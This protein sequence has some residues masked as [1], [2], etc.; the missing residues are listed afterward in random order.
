MTLVDQH[1]ARSSII[2]KVDDLPYRGT[3]AAD[4]RLTLAVPS[5]SDTPVLQWALAD[6]APCRQ[7]AT[8][9]RSGQLRVALVWT[10]NADLQMHVIEPNSSLGS[11]S[12]TFHLTNPTSTVVTAPGCSARLACRAIWFA[13][14][15]LWWI[16]PGS[17]I[18]GSSMRSSCITRLQ[19]GIALGSDKPPKFATRFTSRAHAEARSATAKFDRW[20]FSWLGVANRRAIRRGLRT[21]LSGSRGRRGGLNRG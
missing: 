2:V 20:H 13:C 18:V 15:S 9:V 10:G 21:S 1:R 17:A 6:G 19:K 12:G 8:V 11:P 16:P 3:F 4:G 5:I 14:S 7:V